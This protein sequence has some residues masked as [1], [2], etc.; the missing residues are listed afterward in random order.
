M[1]AHWCRYELKSVGRLPAAATDHVPDAYAHNASL[2]NDIMALR[3]EVD[4]AKATAD[5]ASATWDTM[6]KERDFHRM[7][8]KRVA[9]VSM[10]C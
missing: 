10:A 8:H 3:A 5:K 2:S 6:R 7:H 1:S 4:S 9:Q